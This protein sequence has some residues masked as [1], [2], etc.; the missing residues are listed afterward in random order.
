MSNYY[1]LHLFN[2]LMFIRKKVINGKEYAYL[3]ENK[4]NKKKKQSRQ[5]STKYLGKVI[6]IGIA[7]RQTVASTIKEALI[8][9]FI[10]KGFFQKGESLIKKGIVIDLKSSTVKEGNK[11]VCLEINEGFLC[12]LTLTNLLNFNSE[13]LNEKET[14]KSIAESFISAG[15]NLHHTSF[16]DIYNNQIKPSDL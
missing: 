8:N 11:E 5:K 10:P 15:I 9:E 16:I 1:K 4:Y 13:N 2:K 3:V 14:I 7:D 12:T 6:N